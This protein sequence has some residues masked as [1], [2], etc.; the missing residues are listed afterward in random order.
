MQGFESIQTHSINQLCVTNSYIYA[1]WEY[2]VHD[3]HQS[4]VTGGQLNLIT[5]QLLRAGI[6]SNTIVR[7]KC[8]NI[9]QR[10]DVSLQ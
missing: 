2:I 10:C 1:R 6:A 3:K 7:L 5:L 8:I 9:L 4:V